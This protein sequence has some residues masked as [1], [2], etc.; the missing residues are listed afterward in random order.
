MNPKD[1]N[2]YLIVRSLKAVDGKNQRGYALNPGDILKVGRIEY[3]VI[4]NQ[5][6][7]K[8]LSVQKVAETNL[9]ESYFDLTNQKVPDDSKDLTCRYC[10][11]EDCCADVDSVDNKLMFPCKCIGSTGGVHFLC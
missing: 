11:S 8:N 10:L 6:G 2:I 7:L 1:Q 9:D 5:V 4:E 3:R